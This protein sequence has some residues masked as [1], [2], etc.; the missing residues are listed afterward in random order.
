MGGE[1]GGVLV[2]V[3]YV[4]GERCHVSAKLGPGWVYEYKVKWE[5]LPTIISRAIHA[6]LEQLGQS[7]RLVEV[8]EI[9]GRQHARLEQHGSLLGS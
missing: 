8:R 4:R 5:M 9:L 6:Q 1:F 3:F 2:S 7:S